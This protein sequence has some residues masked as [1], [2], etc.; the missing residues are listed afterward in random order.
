MRAGIIKLHECTYLNYSS[1]VQKAQKSLI[2][3]T[4]LNLAKYI[5]FDLL[6]FDNYFRRKINWLK[7]YD[8]KGK[9]AKNISQMKIWKH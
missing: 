3:S 5:F 1:K 7:G 4:V 9:N 6:S 8:T 2:Y